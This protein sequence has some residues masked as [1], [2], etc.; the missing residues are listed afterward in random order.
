ML[1]NWLVIKYIVKENSSNIVLC[2]F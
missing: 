2:I 1:L